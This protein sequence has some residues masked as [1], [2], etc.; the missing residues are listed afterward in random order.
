MTGPQESHRHVVRGRDAQG[1]GCTLI[2]YRLVDVDR[3]WRAVR[4]VVVAPDST[5]RG[6]CALSPAQAVEIAAAMLDAAGGAR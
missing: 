2:V 5:E 1:H 4:V 6:A 3:D